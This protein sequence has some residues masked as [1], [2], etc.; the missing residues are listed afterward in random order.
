M[1]PADRMGTAGKTIS[2]VIW[3]YAAFVGEKLSLFV[4]TAILARLL[5]PEQFGIIASALL[6]LAAVDAFRDFGVK[7]ALIWNDTEPELS[8]DTAFWF[9]VVLGAV[10]TAGLFAAAP[11]IANALH[12]PLLSDILRLMAFAFVLNGLGM[13][14]EAM[15]QKRLLFRP[16]YVI[17]LIA[18]LIKGVISVALAFADYGVWAL[19]YGFVIGIATR[20]AGRWLILRWVPRLRFS[21][22]RCIALIRYGRHLLAVNLLDIA[23]DRADQIAIVLMLG[24]VSLGYYYIAAR[25][26][27]TVIFH[28]NI[29]LTRVLFPAY[30]RVKND[31]DQLIS[32]M[33][34]TARYSGYLVIPIGIGLAIVADLAVVVIFGDQWIPAAPVLSILS[35]AGIGYSLMWST[36]D[37]AKA[38]GRPDILSKL[39]VIEA[40][41]SLPIIFGMVWV[42]GTIE[43][44]AL[45]LLVSL[46]IYNVL[47]LTMMSRILGFRA[48]DYLAVFRSATI[49]AAAMIAAVSLLRWYV[50]FASMTAELVASVLLGACV[51]C[52]TLWWQDRDRLLG[53]LAFIRG[54]MDAGSREAL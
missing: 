18:A 53:G 30:A 4:T 52:A 10:L 9:H 2:G 28:F 27:E 45:G 42:F 29:V 21:M 8:A 46:V 38:I 54:G 49:A 1:E 15:L 39:T 48:L 20:T 41:Y 37:V 34:Q 24:E 47:R 43:A 40:L 22:D 6:V 3:A 19:A 50:P 16:R 14:H 12:A 35:L 7:D 25:I 44:A 5:V 33:L 51:Y 26:P 13:T 32:Y 11:L 31:R 17:D 36:G 23:I